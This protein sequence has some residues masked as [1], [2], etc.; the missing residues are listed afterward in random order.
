M[1]HCFYTL[2]LCL[3]GISCSKTKIEPTV[4]NT[5]QFP[6]QRTTTLYLIKSGN[7]YCEQNLPQI[8]NRSSMS[9]RITFDS[10][11]IYTSVTTDNQGDVNKLMGFSDCGNDHQQNSARLGWSWSGQ[12]LVLYAYSYV[13][14]VRIIKNLGNFGLNKPINCSIKAENGYYYFK[15]DNVSDSIAR[16]CSGYD[17]SR[18]KL[19]P[20]FG[21]DETAPHDVKIL[22]AE[23]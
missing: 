9:A 5:I 10:S 16:Y 6:D 22:I 1:K 13:N 21:G 23:Y 7:H 19:F 11:A 2:F 17:S 18:Y 14:K 15:A 8:M 4:S 12:S 3:A 20:Y